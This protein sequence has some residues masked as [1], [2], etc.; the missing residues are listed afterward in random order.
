MKICSFLPAGTEIACALG[1][2]EQLA[3]VSHECD[4][5]SSVR[6]KPVVV[7]SAVE[8][9]GLANAEIHQR[10]QERLGQGESLYLIDVPLLQGIQPDLLLTQDLCDVCSISTQLTLEA[11]ETLERKPAI[12]SLTPRDLEGVWASILEVGR[13]AGSKGDAE[14][15]VARVRAR[16]KRVAERCRAA[17][18]AR[19][20]FLE[21]TDPRYAPGHW[22]PEMVELAG[23]QELFGRKGEPSFEVR[24]EQ[25]CEAQPEVLV[26]GPCGYSLERAAGEMGTLA[27]LPGFRDLPAFHERRIFVV[28]SGSY[29][30]R[31]GPRLADGVEILAAILHPELGLWNPPPDSYQAW[32]F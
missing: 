20:C 9:A 1:L 28:D 4:Y 31:P 24:W 32:T 15:L 22:L 13:A 21:W 12:V 11:I 30:S 6:S 7:R 26:I 10:I 5:P 23:G 27:R 8:T 17:A 19:V 3:G 14:D 29:F 25:I 18:R 16:V 2:E